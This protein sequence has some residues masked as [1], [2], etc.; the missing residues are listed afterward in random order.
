MGDKAKSENAMTVI[1]KTHLV[2][3][4]QRPIAMARCAAR[5]I[6]APSGAEEDWDICSLKDAMRPRPQMLFHQA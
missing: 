2:I 3:P 5:N 6:P 1:T 4:A